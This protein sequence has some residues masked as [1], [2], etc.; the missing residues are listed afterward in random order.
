MTD[1]HRLPE[2]DHD[3]KKLQKDFR[4]LEDD[5]ANFTI[6]LIPRIPDGLHG[7]VRISNLGND[8]T[9]PVYKVRKF[10]CQSL[11]GRGVNSGIRLIYTYDPAADNVTFIEI[12]FKGKQENE[13]RERILRFMKSGTMKS[14]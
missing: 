8:V 2:F 14:S 1:F 13:D 7:I 6:A 3:M 12:Y 5:L 4:S 11:K 10:R 9:D